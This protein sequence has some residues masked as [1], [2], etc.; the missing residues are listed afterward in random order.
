TEDI[1][2][3]EPGEYTVTITDQATCETV[4][5]FTVGGPPA[6]SFDTLIT[7]PT[8]DGGMDG[9]LT[10]QVNGGTPPY[11]YSFGGDAF[12][13]SNTIANIPIGIYE[14]IIRDANG[15][16]NNQN[17]EVNELV[18]ELDPLVAAIQE[19]RCNGE[20]NG[21]ITGD[22]NNGQGPYEYDFN[23]GNG[24]ESSS[25]LDNI[26]SGSYDVNV[27]DANNC[28]G[29]FT[30]E[31]MD[32]PVIETTLDAMD[33]SCAGQQDGMVAVTATGGRPDY[34]YLWSNNSTA[35]EISN[36]GPGTY[37]VTVTDANGCPEIVDTFIIEPQSIIGEVVEVVDNICFGENSGSVSL[38]ATGGS[39]GFEYSADGINFQAD[40]VLMGLPAGDYVLTIR[41]S[42][43]CID[44]VTASIT[45]PTEFII[46]PGQNLD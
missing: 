6:F 27:R 4:R 34:T 38:N 14:V 17:I 36:L 42:E 25:I 12:Q 18:L 44:T 29:V 37:T 2:G 7:M 13:A 43:G 39:P 31:V 23:Q 41:D 46:D 32:P 40:S 26:H 28:Q 15:C 8:C 21:R 22:I 30:F 35:P 16:T 11:E 20:S 5:T 24:F 45:Q 19:P 3:I 33:I 9:V 1:T 10:L